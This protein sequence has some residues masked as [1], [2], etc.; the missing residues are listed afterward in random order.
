MPQPIEYDNPV[1]ERETY[2]FTILF[3]SFNDARET[4]YNVLYKIDKYFARPLESIYTQLM[5]EARTIERFL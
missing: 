1:L 3:L 4:L 5:V 2:I